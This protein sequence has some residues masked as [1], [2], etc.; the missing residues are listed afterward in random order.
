MPTVYSPPVETYVA[1]GTV[2]LGASSASVVFSSI[3]QGYRDLIVTIAGSCNTT[4]SPSL[5]F[6]G[7][8]GNNYSNTR[9]YDNNSTGLGQS[10]VAAYG[11]IGIMQNNQ[12]SV[13][14]NIMDYSVNDKHKVTVSNGGNINLTNR[15]EISRW[16][17]YSPITQVSVG[18]DGG[19]TYNAGTVISLYGIGA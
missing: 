14:A 9:L 13:I 12:S 18:F 2:T 6:N 4:G 5:R 10:F 17:N 8:S 3:P 11:S 15:T 16:A 7:D 1:L 19:A